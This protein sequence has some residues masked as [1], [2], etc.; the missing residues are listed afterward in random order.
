MRSKTLSLFFIRLLTWGFCTNYWVWFHILAGA[1]GSKFLRAV[2]HRPAAESVLVI[3]GLAVG[4][5]ICEA[6]LEHPKVVYGSITR[7]M[8]DSAGD[9]IGAV[10][11]ALIVAV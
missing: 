9:V 4:W 5:E 10:A 6:A 7:F 1:A 2:L 8:Y 11:A 3:A